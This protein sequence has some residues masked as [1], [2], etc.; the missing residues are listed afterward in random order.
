MFFFL[1]LLIL[2]KQ[3]GNFHNSKIMKFVRLIHARSI[4]LWWGPYIWDFSSD[5][6]LL[7]LINIVWSLS[8]TMRDIF[9]ICYCALTLFHDSALL[10]PTNVRSRSRYCFVHLFIIMTCFWFVITLV[11]IDFLP[12]YHAYFI[13]LVKTRF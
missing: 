9:C 7:C 6:Q 8:Y 13:L 5:R 12:N 4:V 2:N 10:L 11:S 1:L 3:E